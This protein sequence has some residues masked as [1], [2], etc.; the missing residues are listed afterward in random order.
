MLPVLSWETLVFGN[1]ARAEVS[2][3]IRPH[4]FDGIT[5]RRMTMLARA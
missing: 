2:N 3:S 5:Q 1:L 4:T